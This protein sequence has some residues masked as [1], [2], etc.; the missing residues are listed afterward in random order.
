A[1][2]M[3]SVARIDGC[4]VRRMTY[5]SLVA[6]NIDALIARVGNGTTE[7]TVRTDPASVPPG[8]SP[9]ST[10]ASLARAAG[11]LVYALI[12]IPVAIAALQALEISSIAQPA[13]TMLNEILEAIPRVVAAALWIGI[14]FIAARFLKTIIEAILPPTGFDEAILSTGVLPTSARPS[15][16]VA[17]I[18]MIAVVLTA[19]IEA[20]R[21]LGGDQIA[22]FLAQVTELGGKVIFGTLIIVVGIFLARIIA[23]LVGS[24]TGEGGYAQTMV[25]YA[26]IA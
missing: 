21:Q 6:T 20:A 1:R 26:I 23:K 9:G 2:L 22:I 14:A 4:I 17:N 19:S 13:T 7:G 16:I 5:A 12:V 8:A 11:V 10:R 25:R 18:A 24:G 15:R 3:L